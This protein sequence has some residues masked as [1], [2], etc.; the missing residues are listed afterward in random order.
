[1]DVIGRVAC[2]KLPLFKRLFSLG[3][4]CVDKPKV[5][6]GAFSKEMYAKRVGRITD[7]QGKS[8]F[9][10]EQSFWRLRK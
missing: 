9:V 7:D 1:M 6:T 3:K 4:Q 2:P 5:V 8:Q 10:R